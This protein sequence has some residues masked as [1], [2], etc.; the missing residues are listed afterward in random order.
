MKITKRAAICCIC[1]SL[2][3]AGSLF[4][5]A[6]QTSDVPADAKWAV[7]LDFQKVISSRI[8]LLVLEDL[9]SKGEMQKIEAFGKL[10]DFNP[11]KDLHGLTVYS[12]TFN[13]DEGLAL[14]KGRFD[15]E[16]VKA[17]IE[18]HG[19][20]SEMEQDGFKIYQ[21]TNEKGKRFFFCFF[22]SDTILFS[23]DLDLVKDELSV[24]SGTKVSLK[25]GGNLHEL[26]ALPAG[27]FIAASAKG[28]GHLTHNHPHARILQKAQ[29]ILITM[30][31]C[32][33]IDF[34]NITLST[35]DEEMAE[36]VHQIVQGIIAL[37]M[38][39]GDEDPKLAKLVRT[40]KLE[41]AGKKVTARVSMPADELF[42]LLKEAR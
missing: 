13:E 2:L 39:L 23:K 14:V 19:E 15:V 34:L 24:L 10:F 38:M 26:N 12:K 28:F 25:S 42:E 22:R 31:E 8:G 20:C 33:G 30:G 4:G 17:L 11:L 3:L 18:T 5:G 1:A 41:R 36:Q 6:L 21:G 40:V 37:G 16:K 35:A 32:E 7:H 27:T 9:E 29:G